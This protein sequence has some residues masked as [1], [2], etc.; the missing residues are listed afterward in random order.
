MNLNREKYMIMLNHVLDNVLNRGYGS[1]L[2]SALHH[3]GIFDILDLL[4]LTYEDIEDLK[5]FIP[6]SNTVEMKI[7][8]SSSV[9]NVDKSL[10]SAFIS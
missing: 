3:N 5:Y 2:M 7:S 9:I 8:L 1:W 6:S 10:L 4:K